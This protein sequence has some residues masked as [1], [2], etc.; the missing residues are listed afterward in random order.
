MVTEYK[1][2]SPF[3]PV[4]VTKIEGCDIQITSTREKEY[5]QFSLPGRPRLSRNWWVRGGNIVGWT[6]RLRFVADGVSSLIN[7][8]Q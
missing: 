3:L 2:P 5:S 1:S 7:N 4:V 8:P 6:E